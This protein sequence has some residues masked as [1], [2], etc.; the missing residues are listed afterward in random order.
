MEKM[1]AGIVL[2]AYIPDS[3]RYQMRL[4]EWAQQRVAAGGAPITLR[5]VK[6]ANMEM[7]RFDAALHWLAASSIQDQS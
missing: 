3:Y 7:E 6:G 2:Q 5:V 4:I 1:A